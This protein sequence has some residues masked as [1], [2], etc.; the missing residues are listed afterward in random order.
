MT[1]LTPLGGLLLAIDLFARA[2]GPVS[3]IVQIIL[4]VVAAIFFL[5]DIIRPL[6]TRA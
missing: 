2:E 6:A 1:V 3:K 5:V 4:I